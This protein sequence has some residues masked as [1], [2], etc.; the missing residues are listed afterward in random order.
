MKTLLSRLLHDR[1][2]DNLIEY[3]L[4][5]LLIALVSIAAITALGGAFDSKNR[6]GTVTTGS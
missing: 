5:A 4:L 6:G 1:Q 2:G 3:A